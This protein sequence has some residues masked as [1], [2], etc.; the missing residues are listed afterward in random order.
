MAELLPYNMSATA[1]SLD[2]HGGRVEA[3][4]AGNELVVQV[5][6]SFAAD[7]HVVPAGGGGDGGAGGGGDRAVVIVATA[8]VVRVMAASM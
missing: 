8:A 3:A 2:E 5:G 4:Y 6:V 1:T 7:I